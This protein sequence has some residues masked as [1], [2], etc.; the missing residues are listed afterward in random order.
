MTRLVIWSSYRYGV[1]EVTKETPTRLYGKLVKDESERYSYSQ[2]WIDKH[3]AIA[4]INHEDREMA[5]SIAR[6]LIE[7]LRDIKDR[8]NAEDVRV[9]AKYQT[10]RDEALKMFPFEIR[11][12]VER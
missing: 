2:K 1:Y 5:I 3:Q 7:R 11:V 12:G 9:A 10:E 8:W 4:E 6:A